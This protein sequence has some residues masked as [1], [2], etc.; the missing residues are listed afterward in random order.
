MHK[1]SRATIAVRM[2]QYFR[3]V[4]RLVITELFFLKNCGIPRLKR[5]HLAARDG[6]LRK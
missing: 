6:V 3:L 4:G 5:N 2:G 1:T